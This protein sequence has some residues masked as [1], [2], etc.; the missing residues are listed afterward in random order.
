M[1]ACAV[2]EFVDDSKQGFHLDAVS[3]ERTMV[4]NNEGGLIWPRQ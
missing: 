2:I 1:L 4:V 3:M